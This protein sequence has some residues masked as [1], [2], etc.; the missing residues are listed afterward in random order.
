MNQNKKLLLI[1]LLISF[2]I[3]LLMQCESSNPLISTPDFEGT[4][5]L[6]WSD[7]PGLQE[8]SDFKLGGFSSIF[9]MGG[10][11]YVLVTNRG[12]VLNSVSGILEKINFLAP[13]F[14][15]EI[16][17]IKLNDKNKIEVVERNPILTLRGEKVTGLPS[18]TNEF[19]IVNSSLELQ[20]WG[21]NP[22]GIVYSA[23]GNFFWIADKYGPSFYQL[24]G[25]WGELGEQRGFANIVQRLDPY[26]GLRKYYMKR[27]G[28]GGFSGLDMDSQGRLVAIIEKELL[29]YPTA[30]DSVGNIHV[31]DTLE[32]MK[33]RRRFVRLEPNSTDIMRWEK[34]ALYEVEPADYDGIAEEEISI[35]GLVMID[36]TTCFINEYGKSGGNV[37]N[38][39]VKVILPDSIWTTPTAEGIFGKSL[40]TLTYQE[41]DSAGLSFAVKRDIIDISGDFD[42]PVA[43]ITRVGH[44]KIAVLERHDYGI[45]NGNLEAGTY[46]VIKEDVNI[47]I[48]KIK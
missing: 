22:G 43:G 46:D 39:L 44:D 47:K 27:E 32:L 36:D 38:L 48:I 34:S 8:G 12:P 28:D 13:D 9:Y 18:T 40:E 15:P 10:R 35:S 23:D 29:N 21:I 1:I 42:K 4:Y 2:S 19:E 16:V 20:Y 24:T 11:E 37:R 30:T 41:L 14:T 17:F 45:E 3:L 31:I 7:L 5:T 6:S 26:K 25:R 33:N